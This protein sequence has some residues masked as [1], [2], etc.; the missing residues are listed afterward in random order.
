MYY[1]SVFNPIYYLMFTGVKR[2][3]RDVI[4]PIARGNGIKFKDIFNYAFY[5]T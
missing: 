5:I 2:F 3:Y 1:M 4:K